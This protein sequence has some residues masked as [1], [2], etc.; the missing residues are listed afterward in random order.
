MNPQKAIGQAAAKHFEGF[1]NNE[2]TAVAKIDATVIACALDADD[3]VGGY[4][5]SFC[6]AFDWNELFHSSKVVKLSGTVL[7]E[8][9]GSKL[10]HSFF[11]C[12]PRLVND[13]FWRVNDSFI[14]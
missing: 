8:I 11:L 12:K 9:D 5:T 3:G 6:V 7:C 13:R 4:K 14:E 2:C 1:G 10:I